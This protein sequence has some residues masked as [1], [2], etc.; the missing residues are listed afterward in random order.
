[1]SS[2]PVLI[3]T[4]YLRWTVHIFTLILWLCLGKFFQVMFNKVCQFVHD[5][6]S[7]QWT[8]WGPSWEGIF[9]SSDSS[10]HLKKKKAKEQCWILM[11]GLRENINQSNL[12]IFGLIIQITLLGTMYLFRVVTI[13]RFSIFIFSRHYPITEKCFWPFLFLILHFTLTLAFL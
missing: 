1:M 9:G 10:F 8:F 2:V 3:K 4:M 6:R 12:L 11:K 13:D 7:F 5:P